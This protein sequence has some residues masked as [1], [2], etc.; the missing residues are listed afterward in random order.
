MSF[1][2]KERDHAGATKEILVSFSDSKIN[3]RI[4][5]F[6]PNGDQ[7]GQSGLSFPIFNQKIYWDNLS[8]IWINENT[9]EFCNK[10]IKLKVFA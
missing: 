6:T 4:F 9:M 5:Y 1:K 2:V 7:L 3:L 8:H 10:L